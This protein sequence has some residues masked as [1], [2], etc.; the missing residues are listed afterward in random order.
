MAPSQYDNW[1]RWLIDTALRKRSNVMSILHPETSGKFQGNVIA[2][3]RS[4]SPRR[5]GCVAW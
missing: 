1:N 5:L 3:L 4:Q 2:S